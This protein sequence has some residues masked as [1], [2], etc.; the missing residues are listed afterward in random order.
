MNEKN[1]CWIIKLYLVHFSFKD[2]MK[3]F[4]GPQIT[5]QLFFFEEKKTIQFALVQ[6]SAI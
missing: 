5:F 6:I 4:K 2:F 3:K 1:I